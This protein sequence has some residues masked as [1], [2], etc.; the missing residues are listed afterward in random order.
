MLVIVFM[1]VIIQGEV[2]PTVPEWRIKKPPGE[3]WLEK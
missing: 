1:I 3:E 2:L